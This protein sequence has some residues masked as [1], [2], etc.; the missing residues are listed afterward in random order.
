MGSHHEEDTARLVVVREDRSQDLARH[1][2]RHRRCQGVVVDF[3]LLPS[4][5]LGSMI[6]AVA[7]PYA[8]RVCPERAWRL[9]IPVYCLLLSAYSFWKVLPAVLERLGG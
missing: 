9:F 8:T 5:L 4:M 2:P 3:I 6:A 7:A 1:A